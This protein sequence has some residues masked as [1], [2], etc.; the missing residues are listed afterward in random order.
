MSLYSLMKNKM[1]IQTSEFTDQQEDGALNRES[2]WVT[3]EQFRNV[4]CHIQEKS[5]ARSILTDQY[6]YLTE[7]HKDLIF[8]LN[9]NLYLYNPL[10]SKNQTALR[11]LV[12]RNDPRKLLTEEMLNDDSNFEIYEFKGQIEEVKGLNV[13]S[14]RF[15]VLLC[16]RNN[17]WQL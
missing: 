12:N 9:R 7:E 1:T 3:I 10:N 2:S 5:A 17:R 15:Y 13:A 11:I 4:R 8:H 6:S 16:E 14:K